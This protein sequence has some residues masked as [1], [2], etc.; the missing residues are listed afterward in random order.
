MPN[1]EPGPCFIVI[2]IVIIVFDF[3]IIESTYGGRLHDSIDVAEEQL[4]QVIHRTVVRGG[5]IIIPSFAL[6][7]TQEIVYSLNNLWN[8]KKLPRIP[9]FV[10]SPL[11]VNITKVF[12]AHPECFDKETLA[13]T[14]VGTRRIEDRGAA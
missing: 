9:V 10:D 4:Y 13:G 7:R 12:K 14:S 5:K 3:I 11:A 6:E 1:E 8:A 2:G